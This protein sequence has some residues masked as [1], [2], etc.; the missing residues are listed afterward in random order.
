[1]AEHTHHPN[2]LWNSVVGPSD[3][4]EANARSMVRSYPQL[5]AAKYAVVGALEERLPR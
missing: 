2:S 4:S 1:M 5:N 3:Y